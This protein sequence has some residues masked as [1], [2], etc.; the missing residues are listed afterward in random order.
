MWQTFLAGRARR[1]RTEKKQQKSA[2]IVGRKKPKQ[3]TGNVWRYSKQKQTDR[4][5]RKKRKKKEQ[6]KEENDRQISEGEREKEREKATD[7][8]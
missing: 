3:A 2:K 5:T 7:T 1:L 8:T 6:N 4:R